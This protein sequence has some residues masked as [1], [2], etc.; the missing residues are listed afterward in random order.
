MIPFKFLFGAAVGA[1]AALF[2]TP[3]NGK[4]NREFV[5]EKMDVYINS[6][7]IGA[8]QIREAV[9]KIKPVA[10]DVSSKV[11]DTIDNVSEQA[12][13]AA[14]NVKDKIN[15]AR[16]KIAEQIVNNQAGTKTVQAQ[17]E[18]A[19]ESSAAQVASE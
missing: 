13:P 15:D 19:I 5:A 3:K 7:Q 16:D 8:Q 4:E 6:D 11:K 18:D 14:D 17:V 12:K 9:E 10:E 2:L 1:G